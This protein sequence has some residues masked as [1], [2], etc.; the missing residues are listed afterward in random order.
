MTRTLFSAVLCTLALV[1]QANAQ[2]KTQIVLADGTILIG[3]INTPIEVQTKFGKLTIPV[4]EMHSASLGYNLTD[5]EVREVAQAIKDL[6]S[7]NFKLRDQA[8]RCL[9]DIGER[10]YVLMP[11]EHGGPM[12]ETKDAG[13]EPKRRIET[14]IKDT[15]PNPQ[16][17]YD[18]F[19][20]DDSRIK[21]KILNKQIKITHAS[22]G[23]LTVDVAQIKYINGH[24]NLQT[25][26]DTDAD[27]K[28]VVTITRPTKLNLS[29]NGEID[30][31]PQTPGQYKS[32]PKGYNTPGKGGT[33]MA[34]ALIG[35]LD[36][37]MPFLIGENFTVTD[38]GKLYLKI[39]ENPWNGKSQ[40]SYNVRIERR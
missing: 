37:G 20:T 33:F 16:Y 40:G 17:L 36:N 22:L 8:Q 21:G 11:K 6:D 32:T 2:E 4:K 38:P 12:P 25:T 39:V 24:S 26:V 34:G 14:W 31:W 30:L 15:K 13:L 7:A 23:E 18:Y 27:W 9:K 29:A 10:A 19:D 35:K 1:S 28:E 5:Q 3:Q